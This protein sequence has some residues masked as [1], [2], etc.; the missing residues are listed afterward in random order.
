MFA[1]RVDAGR[2]L[3]AV[4]RDRALEQPVVVGLPRGGVVVAAEVAAALGAP[5][6]VIVV[7]KLGLPSQPELAMGAIG[8][9][10]VRVFDDGLIRAAGV[11]SEALA[12]VEQRE[13]AELT[14]RAA[15][16]RAVAPRIDVTGR[17]VVV[18]DDGIATGATARAACLVAAAH[19]AGRVVLAAPV[20]P[21][22]IEGAFADVAAE[23]ICA[24]THDKFMAIGEWYRDF[25]QTPE[26]DVVDLLVRRR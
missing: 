26:D 15:R 20:G 5:L 25:S 10:G 6:D 9:D 16:F 3:A 2:Q 4:L 19:G 23:V 24:E 8:E 11:T 13:R 1:D 22:G 12:A 17:T 14:R 18:V 7:R 21:A